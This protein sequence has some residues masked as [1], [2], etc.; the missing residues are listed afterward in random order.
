MLPE[1]F[2]L[3]YID[4]DGKEKTP[5]M[6]H[7]APLGSLERFLAILIEHYGG[8]FPLWL[9]PVQM[10][11]IPIAERHVGQAAQ[12]AQKLSEAGIRVEIDDK[13]EPMGAKIRNATLQKV[14]Y[15]GIIGD[16][17]IEAKELSI[18]TRAGVNLKSISVD[19]VIAKLRE[20]IETKL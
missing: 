8:A 2:N 18:R 14:P 9:S 6:I 11:I 4:S 17:E 20:E 13:N 10:V 5:V 16:K 1:R 19:E 15:M 12:Y 3:K 7:R